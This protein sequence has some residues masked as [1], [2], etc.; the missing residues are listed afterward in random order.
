MFHNNIFFQIIQPKMS[1]RISERGERV[2]KAVQSHRIFCNMPVI[3]EKIMQ[4]GA[5]DDTSVIDLKIQLSANPKA[6]VSNGNT[7]F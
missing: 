4:K 1:F 2:L 7:V 5:P 3:Q 6:A